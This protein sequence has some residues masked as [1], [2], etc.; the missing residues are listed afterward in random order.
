MKE[1]K[2]GHVE[3]VEKKKKEVNVIII[4]LKIKT[5]FKKRIAKTEHILVIKSLA[6][7]N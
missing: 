6:K 2:K 5:N 7:T 1:Q 3:G 4:F